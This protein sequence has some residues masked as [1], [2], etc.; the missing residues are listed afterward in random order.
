MSTDVTSCETQLGEVQLTHSNN[1]S[2]HTKAN[3]RAI[4]NL[5]ISGGSP[6]DFRGI[7]DECFAELSPGEK[8]RFIGGLKFIVGFIVTCQLDCMSLWRG[9]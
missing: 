9:W 4:F 2:Y 3:I 7:S 5:E 1:E 6:F 8:R